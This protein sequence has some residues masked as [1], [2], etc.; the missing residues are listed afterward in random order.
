MEWQVNRLTCRLCGESIDNNRPK[1]IDMPQ[2]GAGAVGIG[3]VHVSC[4]QEA[5][6]R[7]S[8]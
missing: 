7:T 1:V 4:A 5:A 8:K 6:R 2:V 3:W